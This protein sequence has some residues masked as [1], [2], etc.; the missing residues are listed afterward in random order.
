MLRIGWVR[1]TVMPRL[2]KSSA[3]S[4]FILASSTMPMEFTG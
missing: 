2:R 1:F 4:F 3:A